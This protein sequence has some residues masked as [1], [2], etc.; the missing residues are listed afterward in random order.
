M[1]VHDV[2]AVEELLEP[3]HADHHG[4][5]QTDGGPQRVPAADPVPE[6]EHVGRVDA[7]GRHLFPIGGYGDEMLGNRRLVL[8][9]LH[10]PGARSPRVGERLLSGECF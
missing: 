9:V 6:F 5:R 2:G 10:Q 1:L 3:L 7:E 4:N 8:Q